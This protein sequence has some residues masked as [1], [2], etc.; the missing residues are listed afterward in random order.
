M[1]RVLRGVSALDVAIAAAVT[2]VLELEVWTESLEPTG[3]AVAGLGVVGM[4]LAFRRVAPLA[5]LAVGLV[6]LLATVLAGVSLEK[7]VG[8]LFFFVL[9]LYSVGLREE[10]GRAVTG[11]LLALVLTP[12]TVVVSA[13]NGS[14]FDWTDVPFLILVVATPWFVGRAMRGRLHESAELRSRAERVER[15]RVEAIAEERA[16]I[17]RELHDVVAHS[18]TVMVVQAGAAEEMLRLD[19]ERAREPLRAV[20]ETGRQALVEMSRLVGLLREDRDEHGLEPQPG[21]DR[22][23]DLL[24]QVRQ[25][26]LHVE[27]NVEGEPRPLPIG[28]DLS[29]YRI[30]QEALTNTLKH[31]DGRADAAID[32]Q[33]HVRYGLD[34]LELEVLDDG[35]GN[36]AAQ[37]GGDG[38]AGMR[39]RATVFG[40]E[41]DAGPRPESGF[42][43]RARLPL[44]SA[45]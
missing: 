18:V 45:A 14:G 40:G 17:A 31:G 32:V 3:V 15:E 26:G 24:A 20:Q 30:L 7:P 21:L 29:A 1:G 16:R 4:S 42:A 25:A 6:A 36:G 10:I 37:S 22:L 19:P 2:G 8:P 39:E 35:R 44:G 43:V 9:A 5:S 33:L 28:I 27:V 23:D 12:A 11:L 34:A 38:L 41:L 13:R